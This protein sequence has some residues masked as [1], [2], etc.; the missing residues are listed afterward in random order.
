MQHGNDWCGE[1]LTGYFITEKFN[2]CRLF[3]DGKQAY[4][5]S[6]H[7]VILPD[8]WLKVMPSFSIDCELYAGVNGLTK[9]SVA[10]RYS[11]IDDSMNLV[12]F[13]APDIQ[14][15]YNERIKFLQKN[16]KRTRIFKVV[17]YEVCENNDDAIQKLSEVTKKGGEG[18]ML[19]HPNRL[20]ENGRNNNVLKLKSY[21]IIK[22]AS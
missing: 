12:V 5:K 14:K 6:G 7:E 17:D 21:M 16:I 10:I 20:Y 1:D 15:P 4:T 11:K 2:G 3:W 18:L 22:K 9:C 19:Y 13:D 8:N